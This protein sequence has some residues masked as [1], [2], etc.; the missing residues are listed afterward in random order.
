M[1]KRHQAI[2]TANARLRR[3]NGTFTG[4]KLVEKGLHVLGSTCGPKRRGRPSLPK[5]IA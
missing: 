4:I 2:L 5:L 3:E 1:S